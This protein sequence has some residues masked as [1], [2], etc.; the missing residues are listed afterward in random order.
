MS[1]LT[2]KP[3][4]Q[5]RLAVFVPII[6]LILSL[7]VVYP[8]WGR[9]RELKMAIRAQ[10]TELETLRATPIPPA[11]SVDPTAQDS[12]SEPPQFL[13]RIRS[14]AAETGCRLSGFDVSATEKKG[15]APLRAV[16]AR[17]EL[18]GQYYQVRNFVMQLGRAPRLYVIT[19]FSLA[20]KP[21]PG[22]QAAIHSQTGP[23]H[24]SIEIERYVSPAIR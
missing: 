19:D 8:A 1:L 6:A 17:V 20:G 24:A 21:P 14:M 18:E 11:G 7:F 13:G 4:N 12:P 3:E 23:L 15:T 2:L 10:R 9:Y 22:Q 16:R 5:Q